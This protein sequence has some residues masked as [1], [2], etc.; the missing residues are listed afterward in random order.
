MGETEVGGYRGYYRGSSPVTLATANQMGP[1][2]TLSIRTDAPMLL[3]FRR[4]MD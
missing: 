2:E 3:R 1:D 4:V